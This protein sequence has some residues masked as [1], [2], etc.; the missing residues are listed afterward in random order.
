MQVGLPHVLEFLDEKRHLISGL[1]EAA[2]AGL[3]ERFVAALGER[4]PDLLAQAQV[5]RGIDEGAAGVCGGVRW[6]HEC[7]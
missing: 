6:V 5:G 3:Y 4:H 7:M 2:R 1:P